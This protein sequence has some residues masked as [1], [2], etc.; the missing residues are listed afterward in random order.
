M[1]CGV[2]VYYTLYAYVC[3]NTQLIQQLLSIA[4]AVVLW[5]LLYQRQTQ[6]CPFTFVWACSNAPRQIWC[7]RWRKPIEIKAYKESTAVQ[8]FN[9]NLNRICAQLATGYVNGSS[10]ETENTFEY[11]RKAEYV[12]VEVRRAK[13][14][15]L[16]TSFFNYVKGLHTKLSEVVV[17]PS[18][19][20]ISA[21][22]ENIPFVCECNVLRLRQCGSNYFTEE[23][24]DFTLHLRINMCC[25]AYR[26]P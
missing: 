21:A 18:W 15:N 17:N 20:R 26:T 25:K 24:H 23:N 2:R 13:D 9:L 8:W 7:R 16:L 4:D 1:P 6:M 14:S 3:K 11:L 5:D 12:Q 19:K 22:D 10:S